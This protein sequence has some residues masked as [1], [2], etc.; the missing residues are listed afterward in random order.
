MTVDQKPDFEVTAKTEHD[1]IDGG[2]TTC[3]MAVEIEKNVP[4]VD[5]VP[6]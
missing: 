5:E 1:G 2:H 3:F 4:S 6:P